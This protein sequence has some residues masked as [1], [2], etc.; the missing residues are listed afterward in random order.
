VLGIAQRTI[1]VLRAHIPAPKTRPKS[2]PT[3]IQTLGDLIQVKRY[4]KRL[5]L[6]KLAQ[7]MGITTG[8]VRGWEDGTGQPNS[9]QIAL[10]MK[11][12]GFALRE[13]AHTLANAQL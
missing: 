10:L 9:Q 13:W 2:L 3:S 5:T 8:S 11:H 7:K 4:E 1:R 6:W 12:L